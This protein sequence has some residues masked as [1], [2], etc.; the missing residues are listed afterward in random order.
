MSAS[1]GPGDDFSERKEELAEQLE[2]MEEI[3]VVV[4]KF[5][6]SLGSLKDDRDK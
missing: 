3:A 2:E 1:A 6:E 4:D 5:E